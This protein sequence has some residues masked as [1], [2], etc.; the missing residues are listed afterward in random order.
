[1]HQ[2]DL[3]VELYLAEERIVN[4]KIG[5]WNLSNQI[6]KKEKKNFFK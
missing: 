4:S 6:S 1:M 5:Q 3:T 2:T